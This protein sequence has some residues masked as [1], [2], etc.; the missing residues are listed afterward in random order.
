MFC[1]NEMNLTG[2]CN[3]ASC[4]LAN[5]QYATVREE[6]GGILFSFLLLFTFRFLLKVVIVNDTYFVL[7]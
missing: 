3:R 7:K 1:R 6:N 5:S 2:L 4:P